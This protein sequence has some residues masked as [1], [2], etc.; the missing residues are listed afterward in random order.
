MSIKEW[1]WKSSLPVTFV[2]QWIKIN[3]KPHNFVFLLQKVSQN[4]DLF[5][6]KQGFIGSNFIDLKRNWFLMRTKVRFFTRYLAVTLG[7]A[8][9][10]KVNGS[11]CLRVEKSA[12]VTNSLLLP[13]VIISGRLTFLECTDFLKVLVVFRFIYIIIVFP[14]PSK[15]AKTRM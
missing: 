9:Y 12:F 15:A 1:S 8:S 6:G 2:K 3:N 14:W 10:T 5:L 11:K 4:C 7:W 13:L